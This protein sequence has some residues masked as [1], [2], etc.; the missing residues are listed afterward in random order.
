MQLTF[1]E[2]AVQASMARIPPSLYGEKTESFSNS[3]PL[4]LLSTMIILI[5]ENPSRMRFL[6]DFHH[7]ATHCFCV[8]LVKSINDFSF[9]LARSEQSAKHIDR[10]EVDHL[11]SYFFTHLLYPHTDFKCLIDSLHR[12][13]TCASNVV[14]EP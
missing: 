3:L 11:F 4:A 7:C 10:C 9:H 12:L 8:F 13:F 14:D 6:C 5:F 1:C 2:Y